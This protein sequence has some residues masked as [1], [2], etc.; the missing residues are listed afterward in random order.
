MLRYATY[1]PQGSLLDNVIC[2]NIF[3]NIIIIIYIYIYMIHV[4]NLCNR[5]LYWIGQDYVLGVSVLTRGD[6]HAVVAH[7]G[8]GYIDNAR[9][10]ELA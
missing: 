4:Q 5:G 10:S 8:T 2:Y 7:A 3:I 9:G 6:S 1:V